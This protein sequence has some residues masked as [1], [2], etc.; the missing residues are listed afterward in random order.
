MKIILFLVFFFLINS[1]NAIQIKRLPKKVLFEEYK[2]VYLDPNF[3]NDKSDFLGIKE[4]LIQKIIDNINDF[5]VLTAY[6]ETV[7]IDE[8]AVLLITLYIQSASES[9]DGLRTE[10]ATCNCVGC[11]ND[12]VGGLITSAASKVGDDEQGISSHRVPARGGD[13]IFTCSRPNIAKLASEFALQKLGMGPIKDEV[14][15]TYEFKNVNYYA[16]IVVNVFEINADTRTQI[17]QFNASSS[18]KKHIQDKDSFINVR[19]ASQGYSL[20]LPIISSV[21][22]LP[23]PERSIAVIDATNPGSSIS[24]WIKNNTSSPE[25]LSSE[26]EQ[27]VISNIIYDISNKISSNFVPYNSG[28]VEIE[29]EGNKEAIKLI[30]A[31]KYKDAI[32]VLE[33]SST[34]QDLFN[35]GLVYEARAQ[36]IEDFEK[37][38]EYYRLAYITSPTLKYAES[39][40]RT[41]DQLREKNF[42]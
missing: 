9:L 10:F 4:G 31:K 17:M 16:N 22:V 11:A 42:K 12:I 23:V 15:R 19:A 6:N 32:R 29:I 7:S 39:F 24:E 13:V 37:A 3:V 21:P 5:R 36:S 38:A 14:V 35:L 18:F 33:N 26:E 30:N 34:A 1:L 40:T 2:S 8:N 28:S 41:N 27:F 20:I 25:K